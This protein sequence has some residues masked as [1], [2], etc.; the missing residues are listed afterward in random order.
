MSYNYV[1]F[2]P[3]TGDKLSNKCLT[4][5]MLL[6]NLEDVYV[7]K[8][9]PKSLWLYNPFTGDKRL[10]ID[11]VNYPFGEDIIRKEFKKG[12]MNNSLESGVEIPIEDKPT[13][14]TSMNVGTFRISHNY[15]YST[16]TTVKSHLKELFSK[17]II[18]DTYVYEDY[19][20]YLALSDF[21]ENV[22]VP[23][24][25]SNGSSLRP[26]MHFLRLNR[27]NLQEYKFLI[28]KTVTYHN[29]LSLGIN[30]ENNTGYSYQF[31]KV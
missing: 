6:N 10:P 23:Y 19:T 14:P 29:D 17:V 28:T 7:N 27:D 8:Y 16:D 21:F 1:C 12:S 13:E 22:N 3:L 20:L 9:N 30:E 18:L 11:I 5:E 25:P 24:T 4:F 26:L 15:L 31:Y 2:N